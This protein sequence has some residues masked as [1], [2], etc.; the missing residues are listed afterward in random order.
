MYTYGYKNL[1]VQDARFGIKHAASEMVPLKA[2]NTWWKYLTNCNINVDYKRCLLGKQLLLLQN[3]SNYCTSYPALQR[4]GF[5]LYRVQIT[6]PPSL[7]WYR[8]FQGANVYKAFHAEPRTQ[9]RLNKREL[10][11]LT[12][13][14]TCR[15]EAY[16]NNAR[17][18]VCPHK[19]W[20]ISVN[21][22]LI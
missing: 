10:P 3:F 14:S 13:M 19:A 12:M 9:L 6:I 22:F 4:F 17:L 2:T 8:T 18:Y 20:G 7:G 5:L 21:I 15:Y 16:V 11:L 1:D